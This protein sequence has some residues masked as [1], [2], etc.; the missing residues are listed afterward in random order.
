MVSIFDKSDVEKCSATIGSVSVKDEFSFKVV[1]MDL[2]KKWCEVNG[3]SNRITVHSKTVASIG[4]ERLV[5]GKPLPDGVTSDT[6][7]KV[8]TRKK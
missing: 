7:K 6:F 4:K 8:N 1:D 3:Y 5:A 2:L